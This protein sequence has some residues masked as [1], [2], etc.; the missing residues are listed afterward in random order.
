MKNK[1]GFV[2][3]FFVFTIWG[4]NYVL[5][6][7][8]MAAIPP[9]TILLFRYLISVVILFPIL[10]KTRFKKVK[11]EHRKY[12]LIIGA[13]GYSFSLSLTLIGTSL[14]DASLSALLNAL[15][16]ITIIVL[17]TIILKEKITIK[18]ISSIIVSITG[19]YVILGASNSNINMLG[20]IISVFGIFMWST[21]TVMIRKISGEYDPFQIVFYGMIIAVICTLP[22]SII[23]LHFKPITFTVPSILSV[24]YLAIFCTIIAHT[25]WNKSL[26][27]LDAGTCSMFYP[28]QPLTSAIMGVLI[29]HEKLTLNYIIGG[30]LISLG[31]II[32]FIKTKK[33][34]L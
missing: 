14:M 11:R 27:L 23:E 15:N 4:S 22:T 17:A 26:S 30:I 32:A 13:V 25:L 1:I 34:N 6:K 24:L 8:A 7:Y 33:E 16:P 20:I 31:I 19:V 18:K 2:Y 10:K 21:A 28:L 12:F 29:L 3:L 5:S 9:I